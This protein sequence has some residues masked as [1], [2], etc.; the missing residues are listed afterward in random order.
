[1]Q[2]S[3]EILL[4]L[5]PMQVSVQDW[6]HTAMVCFKDAPSAFDRVLKEA[7]AAAAQADGVLI[8]AEAAATA[9]AAAGAGAT[10]AAGNSGGT[11]S[12]EGGSD[13]ASSGREEV[14]G[15]GGDAGG[16]P[17]AWFVVPPY[18]TVATTAAFISVLV[19]SILYH[20]HVSIPSILRPE[21][22][23]RQCPNVGVIMMVP[24]QA[25]RFI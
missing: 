5:C 17:A 9:A 14:G 22:P 8:K 15:G 25:R 13:Q 10:K 3:V 24:P 18:K 23:A 16:G 19:H 2:V 6:L 12:Q 11:S 20:G 7:E 4:P 21:E 1:M